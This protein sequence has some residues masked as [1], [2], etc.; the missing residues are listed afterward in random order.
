MK[1]FS[2]KHKI[3]GQILF[4][5]I[6]LFTSS[7]YSLDKFSKADRVSNYFSG[8]LLLNDNQYEDS[9]KYLKKLNGLETSHINYS[10]KYLYTLIN[11]GNFKEVLNYSTEKQ[12]I[13]KSKV[14][15][16]QEFFISKLRY[17]FSSKIFP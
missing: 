11:S 6:F 15:L 10:V 17:F 4:V 2:L 14:I 12:N 13:G 3:I 16:F 5:I 9:F 8:I 7:A 1:S